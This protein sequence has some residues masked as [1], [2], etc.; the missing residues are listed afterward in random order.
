MSRF[1]FCLN[2]MAN[3]GDAKQ[4]P[5]CGY[6]ENTPQKLPALAPGTLLADRYVVGCAMTENGE[7][8][9]YIAMDT[10]RDR[11][12]VV[13]EYLPQTLCTRK[14]GSDSVVVNES[15]RALYH[16]M[17]E[18]FNDIAKAVKRLNG[19]DCIAPVL[20]IFK[21]NNT[22]YVVYP[23]VQGTKLSELVRR[24]KRLSWDEA[25]PIFM[26]L[27]SALI[28]AHSIG[29]VHFGISPDNIYMKPDGSLVLTGYGIPSVRMAETELEPEMYDGYTPLEQYSVDGDKGKWSDIYA[30]S[31]VI[32]FALIGKQ[33]PDAITRTREPKLPVSAQLAE[34]IP[35]YVITA[36]AGGLQVYAEDRTRTMEELYSALSSGGGRAEARAHVPAYRDEPAREKPRAAN[37]ASQLK[38]KLKD[39][40]E[41]EDAWYKNLSQFQYWL[42][43]TCLGIIVLGTIAVIVF[44]NVRP[45]LA[46]E[47]KNKLPTVIDNGMVSSADTGLEPDMYMVPDLRGIPWTEASNSPDYMMFDIIELGEAYSDDYEVGEIMKQSVA[48][49]TEAQ[50]GT[51]I[52]VTVSL[53]SEMCVIPNIIGMTVLEADI[54]LTEA[55]LVI[56][57]QTEEYNSGVE[58]GKIIDIVGG[59]VGS[60]MK[61]GSAVNILVSLGSEG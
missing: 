24:A 33:P 55:G 22:Q 48:P 20:D 5:K 44:L 15:V 35:T 56:G 3:K 16:D 14:K 30:I 41:N 12:V 4:C 57:T 6:D 60:R 23:Y 36:L 28:Q 54:A 42:L 58:R 39:V 40:V 27:V 9:S 37:A 49:N 38:G 32:L 45:L 8:I 1:D 46:G 7:G 50:Y 34:T 29:L 52:A 11:K 61:R 53:G 19:V 13:R 47:D 59:S 25:R 18:D 21:C 26:P 31:A 17:M 10:E 51:P 43:T 2:C